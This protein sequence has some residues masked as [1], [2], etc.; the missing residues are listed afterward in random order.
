MYGSYAII[1]L[2]EAVYGLAHVAAMLEYSRVLTIYNLSSVHR[3]VF[4]RSLV[5]I[6]CCNCYRGE[7]TDNSQ[8]DY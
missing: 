1:N 3:Y 5:C 4:I 7:Q 2:S 6:N 8:C